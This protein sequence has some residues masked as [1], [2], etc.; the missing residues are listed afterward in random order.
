M[1]IPIDSQTHPDVPLLSLQESHDFTNQ[2]P[3][4]FIC[5][6]VDTIPSSIKILSSLILIF[7]Q[8]TANSLLNQVDDTNNHLLFA[9]TLAATID[10]VFP[11]RG[12]PRIP[13][14]L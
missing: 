10:S 8:L 11:T 12:I 9:Q 4:S 3:M 1:Y 13:I 6:C 7:N 14:N 5:S 2:L